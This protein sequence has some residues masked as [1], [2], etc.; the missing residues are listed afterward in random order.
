MDDYDDLKIDYQKKRLN[1][2]KELEIKLRD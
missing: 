2:L 1:E